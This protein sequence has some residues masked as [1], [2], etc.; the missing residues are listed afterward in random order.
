[1]GIN[2]ALRIEFSDRFSMDAR[3]EY[4]NNERFIDRG[5][6]TG[7]DGKPVEAFQSIV[8]GDAKA[9]VSTLKPICF[10]C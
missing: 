6:P 2:P 5:I 8:F 3:Y 7:V 10:R 4:V 9:N 1:M